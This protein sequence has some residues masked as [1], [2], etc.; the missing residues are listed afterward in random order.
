M[1]LK[2]PTRYKKLVKH[3]RKPRKVTKPFSKHSSEV[4]HTYPDGGYVK[5]SK[6]NG[7]KTR[8]TKTGKVKAVQTF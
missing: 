1:P 3:K 7:R 2:L 6:L 5:R 4:V 8:Y